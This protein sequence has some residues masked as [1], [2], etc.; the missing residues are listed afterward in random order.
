M[1]FAVLVAIIFVLGFSHREPS[2][3]TY[4]AIVIASVAASAWQYLG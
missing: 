3:G 1:A 4:L 2:R